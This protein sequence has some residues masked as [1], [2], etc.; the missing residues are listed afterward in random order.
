MNGP[1]RRPIPDTYDEIQAIPLLRTARQSG[2]LPLASP[3]S[4]LLALLQSAEVG[5]F[6]LA[7]LYRRASSDIAEGRV[8]NAAV[9][10]GWAWGYHRI[11]LLLGATRHELAQTT[12][13]HSLS[14]ADRSEERRV[15]EEW[16]SW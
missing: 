3:E 6:N 11:I 4:S 10:I 9:K 12:S 7:D 1:Q 16:R 15:G 13:G 5:I 14:L 8:G 2:G